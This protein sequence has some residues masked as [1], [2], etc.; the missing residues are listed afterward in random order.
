[1][2]PKEKYR[3]LCE[4]EGARI[5]L[6]QQHWWMD[7]VC[8]GKQWDVLLVERDGHVEGALP[9]LLSRKF[10]IRYVL[11]PQLTQFNGPWYNHPDKGD[12]IAFEH[13]VGDELARQLEGLHLNLFL[14]H[15]A[16]SVKNWL[17]F[18]WHGYHQ[19]TRYTYRFDPLPTPDT[20]PRLADRG[21]TRGIDQVRNTY[22]LDRQVPPAEFAAMHLD[23]WQR[24]AG[25]DLLSEDFILRVVQTALDRQQGLLYGLRDSNQR[26]MAARFVVFDSAC[27]YALLSAMRPDT[28]R[29]AM[30]FL[31]WELICSLYGRT[32]MFDFEGSMDPGIEH[33]YRSFGTTQTPFFEVSRTRPAL[34]ALLLGLR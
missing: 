13:R 17:P 25:K 8:H 15:F 1:M 22:T 31:V 20:L 29:N 10:G 33:F 3:A 21:R 4:A 27:A 9:Y 19:T 26:L 24:R 30:T 7:T 34:L 23:Y 11:Q 14:Q 16:P 2:T 6:F 5:P 18:H 28:L 12:P 32:R